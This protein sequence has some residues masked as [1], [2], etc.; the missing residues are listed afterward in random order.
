MYVCI[1]VHVHRVV[2]V[3]VQCSCHVCS[4]DPSALDFIFY[5]LETVSL[6]QKL[7]GC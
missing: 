3:E 4:L 6:N 7:F 1:R 5:F 2:N